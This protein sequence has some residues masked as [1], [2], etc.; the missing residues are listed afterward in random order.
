MPG[1]IIS[2]LGPGGCGKTTMLANC[3]FE[4]PAWVDRAK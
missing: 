2:L 4:E 3:G 1:E